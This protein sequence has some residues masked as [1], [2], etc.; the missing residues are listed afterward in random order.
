MDFQ[1]EGREGREGKAKEFVGDFS[2]EII[3]CAL[4]VHSGMGPGLLESVYEE[5]LCHELS[6]MGLRFQRQMECPIR[7]GGFQLSSAL[8]L[9]LLVQGSVIVEVKAVERLLP[10]HDAQVT[11]YLRLTGM[12]LGLLFNFNTIHFRHG[13]RR[14]VLT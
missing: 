10:I 6:R 1:R 5:C 7:Y 14:K 9:D 13:I 3:G 11:T 12:K 4:K 2:Q 8:R